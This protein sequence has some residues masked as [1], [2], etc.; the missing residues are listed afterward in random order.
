LRRLMDEGAIVICNLSKGRLGEGVAHLLGALSR[1]ALPVLF[2]AISAGPK[3]RAVPASGLRMRQVPAGGRRAATG[4]QSSRAGALSEAALT[5]RR[6]LLMGT[7]IGRRGRAFWTIGTPGVGHG[8]WTSI[9]DTA[10]LGKA[11]LPAG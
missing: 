5:G 4:Q 10:A 1:S 8:F 7:E 3:A 6:G 11:L 9:W 2:P